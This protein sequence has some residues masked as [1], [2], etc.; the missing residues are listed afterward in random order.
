MCH[1]AE[2][3]QHQQLLS[4]V[5]TWPGGGAAG[6]IHPPTCRYNYSPA[7]PHRGRR[8]KEEKRTDTEVKKPTKMTLTIGTS[9]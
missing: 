9:F 5:L 7:S 4:C 2:Q 3:V 6:Y 8:R 1:S